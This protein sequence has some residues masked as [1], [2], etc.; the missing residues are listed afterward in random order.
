M[1]VPA[2]PG[3]PV[4]HWPSVVLKP[5]TIQGVGT[6]FMNL[7]L[8]LIFGAFA[9]VVGLSSMFVASTNDPVAAIG[10]IAAVGAASC[11]LVIVFVINF[12]LSLMSALRM[13][14]GADEYGPDHAAN[15]RRGWIFKWVGTSLST[16]ATVLVV[17]LLIA[18]SSA[19]LLG[20][21]VPAT[22]YVPLLVT[23]F[24]TG[25]LAAKAQMYRYFVRSLQPPEIRRWSDL[26]SAII[27][28]LAIIG[29]AIVGYFTVRIIDLISNPG[30]VTSAEAARLSGL[31]VGGVFLPAGFA[32]IGYVIFLWIYGKTRERLKGGLYQLYTSMVQA[33]SPPAGWNP[34]PAA[35]PTGPTQ[36]ATTVSSP[37]AAGQGFCGQCGHPL[38]AGALFCL[39]CG[40]RTTLTPPGPA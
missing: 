37:Q 5:D 13:H 3:P 19:F 32:L 7:I 1:T 35:P 29:V 30:Q 2:P 18:G 27:P 21:P 22:V 39:N 15:A 28:S 31:L 17:Y 10:V 40:T 25:G 12:I 6:Y 8:D 4:P 36:G 14:H 38:P 34:Y 11:G 16:A 23:L 20:G 26:A 24:W 9:L 33:V